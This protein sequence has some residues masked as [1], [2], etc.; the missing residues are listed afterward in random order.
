[1]NT[2]FIIA[3]AVLACG[4]IMLSILVWNHTNNQKNRL[5]DQE[6]ET[7]AI[8]K[9]LKAVEEQL[10]NRPTQDT[11]KEIDRELAR[12]TTGNMPH[13]VPNIRMMLDVLKLEENG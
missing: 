13:R 12:L 6:M 9:R 11:I 7:R 5:H 1:M 10:R 3:L 2:V 8:N 4:Y